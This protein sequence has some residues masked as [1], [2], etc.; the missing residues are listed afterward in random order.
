MQVTGISRPV[1]VVLIVVA[2]VLFLFGA[3]KAAGLLTQHT[4]THMRTL[5]AA[6]TIVVAAETGDVKIVAAD[7]S[8]IRLTIKEQRSMWGGGHANVFGD[9]RGLRL[10]DRCDSLP[11]IDD[12]C[13]VSFRLEVPRTTAV[14]LSDGTGDV[15]AENL[16]GRAELR[17]G[18]GDLHVTGMAGPLRLHTD[19][20]DVHVEAPASDI[21]V[22]TATGNIDV[23]ATRPRTIRAQADTGD[24]ALVVPD[25][26][27]AVDARSDTSDEIVDVRVDGASPRTLQA[28]SET[29]DV[30]VSR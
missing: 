14:R 18:T 17:S 9:A 28:H 20:G 1:L 16:E 24:I 21:S 23:V 19:T 4:D 13:D 6:P 22:Q 25:L 15:H 29:G 2:V 5:A 8:D 7:R 12:P 3:G 10:E 26:T 30:V 11:A 27:Y